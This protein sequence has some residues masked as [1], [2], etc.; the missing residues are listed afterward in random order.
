MKP[1]ITPLA[2]GEHRILEST[3]RHGLKECQHIAVIRFDGSLF[4]ANSNYLEDHILDK[5][6]NM[7]A[8]KHVLIVGNGINEIDA[9]G[10]EM[11][12]LLVDR[13]RENNLDISFCGL[14]DQIIDVLKR[15]RLYE[16]IGRDHIFQNETRALLA[17]HR[18]AHYNSEEK[19]CPLMQVCYL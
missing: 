5:I 11:L 14:K 8:L 12:S 17:I 13:L 15:T 19:E 2:M 4:F 6:T 3:G 10:E 18:D 16:K 9:S 7:P 1:V